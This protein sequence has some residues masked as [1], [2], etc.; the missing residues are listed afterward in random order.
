MSEESDMVKVTNKTNPLLLETISELK[1]VSRENEAPIWR[2][3]AKRLERSRRNWAEVNISKLALLHE[4][5]TAVIAGKL[6]GAGLIDRA[7]TIAAFSYSESAAQKIKAVGG[8]ILSIG[9][10]AE[11]NPK[12][13]NVRIM[14]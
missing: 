13:T 4:G 8:E 3:I 5:E 14:G 6:L 12:G 10:L 11:K 2:D 9:E 7:V 1:R